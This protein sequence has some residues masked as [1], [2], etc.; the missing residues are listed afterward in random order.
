MTLGIQHFTACAV[1]DWHMIN[2]SVGSTHQEESMQTAE[3]WPYKQLQWHR[4][5]FVFIVH[6]SELKDEFLLIISVYSSISVII[7]QTADEE[8]STSNIL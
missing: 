3:P 1:V 6:S 2:R 4:F 5:V 7:R 8:A